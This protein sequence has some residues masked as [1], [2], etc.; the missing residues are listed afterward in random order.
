MGLPVSLSVAAGMI[1]VKGLSL[2][3]ENGKKKDEICE[4]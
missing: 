2:D 3:V 4:A 1:L